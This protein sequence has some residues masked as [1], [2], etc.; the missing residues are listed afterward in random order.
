[1]NKSIPLIKICGIQHPE[2]AAFAAKIG[3]DL[4]GVVFAEGSKRKVSKEAAKMIAQATVKEGSQPVGIFTTPYIDEVIQTCLETQMAFAQIYHP[5]PESALQRLRE[6]CPIIAAVK[7]EQGQ[8]APIAASERFTLFDH[9]SPGSG[10]PFH[11]NAFTPPK[12]QPWFLAGGLHPNNVK[13][14]IVLLK[15]TGVDVSSGV[16][17]HGVKNRELIQRFIEEVKQT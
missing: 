12:T 15:P 7:V 2:D 1:M 14:A 4:I 16:E 5:F 6:V 3:A 13:A 9:S 11:W 8:P 10:T 17:M